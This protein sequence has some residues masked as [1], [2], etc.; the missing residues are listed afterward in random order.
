MLNLVNV[1]FEH[2]VRVAV[3]HHKIFIVANDGGFVEPI[4]GDVSSLTLILLAGW[5][6]NESR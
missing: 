4:Q 2:E 6:L 3:D 5:C 1:G